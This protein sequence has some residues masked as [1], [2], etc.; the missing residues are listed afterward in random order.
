MDNQLQQI[1][2]YIRQHISQGFSE[3][4]IRTHLLNN[5]W[6]QE[7]V[8]QAFNQYHDGAALP[9]SMPAQ[10]PANS[11]VPMP[12][13]KKSKARIAGIIGLFVVLGII[14]LVA[15]LLTS[16]KTLDKLATPALQRNAAN[17]SQKNDV[18]MVVSAVSNYVSHHNGMLPTTTVPDSTAG[19][20]DIC[21]AGC[22]DSNKVT[23]TLSYFK[24]TTTAVLFHSYASNLTVPDSETLYIVDNAACKSGNSGIGTQTSSGTVSAAFLYA[25][26]SGSGLVQQCLGF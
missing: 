15:H 11:Y 6:S 18:A 7:A 3:A 17:T 24:S 19:T 22:T 21:G 4:D 20:L 13:Y 5:G 25:S 26:T 1:T 12:P 16:P 10:P 2:D 14:I 8:T 23:V 9:P